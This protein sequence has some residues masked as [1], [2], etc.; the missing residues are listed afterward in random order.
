[1]LNAVGKTSSRPRCV[2]PILKL[3]PKPA[4]ASKI[5][6]AK[7]RVRAGQPRGRG[8][9]AASD[10]ARRGQLASL[11]SVPVVDVD[12]ALVDSAVVDDSFFFEDFRLD[13]WL[14][15]DFESVVYQPDPLN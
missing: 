2:S 3:G 14:L 4:S 15:V 8:L 1:M 13:D 5:L 7:R 10:T 12:D 6:A 11:P 9:Q